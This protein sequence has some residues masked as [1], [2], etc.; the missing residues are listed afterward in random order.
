MRLVLTNDDGIAAPG[1]LAL[2]E[3]LIEFGKIDIIAP[4]HER[5]A[6]SHSLSLREPVILRKV[7]G[8]FPKGVT[9]NAATGTPADCMKIALL[10]YCSPPDVVV[11]GINPGSNV[12]TDIIYSGT[13]AAAFEAALLGIPALA[14]SLNDAKDGVYHFETAAAVAKKLIEKI[15]FQALPKETVLN[16]NVPN[17]PLSEIK[18]YRATHLG[19][20]KFHERYIRRTD[21]R[22]NDYFWINGVMLPGDDDENSDYLALT[23]N[24]ISLTPLHCDLTNRE[25][26]QKSD[27]WLKGLMGE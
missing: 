6:T 15:N 27:T 13:V 18:G 26:A 2:S 10:S 16:V 4:E 1:L 23:E 11:C 25:A 8:I 14:I 17:V 3:A 7:Q 12:S 21:P 9:A 22:G 19:Q 20:T 5:S 24:F